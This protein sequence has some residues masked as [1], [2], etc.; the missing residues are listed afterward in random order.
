MP[1]PQALFSPEQMYVWT[2]IYG[3]YRTIA[4]AFPEFSDFCQN[5]DRFGLHVSEARRGGLINNK[6][7]RV[8]EWAQYTASPIF[9]IL[10]NILQ[11]VNP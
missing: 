11:T 6:D 3:G 1:L 9:V 10:A 5:A 4:V 2:G 8:Y 7:L